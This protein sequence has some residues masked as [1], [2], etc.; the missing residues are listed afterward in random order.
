MAITLGSHH[1]GRGRQRAHERS[2]RG[3]R[4]AATPAPLEEEEQVTP[5]ASDAPHVASPLT[6]TTET[7]EPVIETSPPVIAQEVELNE[8]VETTT[9]PSARQKLMAEYG[10]YSRKPTEKELKEHN[11]FRARRIAAGYKSLVDIFDRRQDWEANP[12]LEAQKL[13]LAEKSGMPTYFMD[14]PLY[15]KEAETRAQMRDAYAQYEDLSPSTLNWMR[16]ADNLRIAR[17]DAVALDEVYKSYERMALAVTEGMEDW[18]V[19]KAFQS[20]TARF[21]E[22]LANT[23]RYIADTDEMGKT[24]FVPTMTEGFVGFAL[25][26]SG[27]DR[28]GML[29]RDLQK[30]YGPA[31]LRWIAGIQSSASRD[32]DPGEYMMPT[33]TAGRMVH[34]IVQSSP[35]AI[36]SMGRSLATNML[37]NLIVPGGGVAVSAGRSLGMRILGRIAN[38]GTIVATLQGAFGEGRMQAAGVYDEALTRGMPKE[39]AARI[40]E[41]VMRKNVALLL[42][43]EY[44]QNALTF[45]LGKGSTGLLSNAVRGSKWYARAAWVGEKML[46]AAFEGVE[47]VGQDLIDTYALGDEVDADALKWSFMVGVGSGGIYSVGGSTIQALGARAYRMMDTDAKI[48]RARK[49]R[50]G[51]EDV[52]AKISETKTASRIPEKMEEFVREATSGGMETVWIDGK[53]L[54]RFAQIADAESIAAMQEAMAAGDE[55]ASAEMQE[56]IEE[57]SRK[58]AEDLGIT[59]MA[60]YFEALATGTDVEVET[61][62]LLTKIGTDENYSIFKDHAKLSPTEMSAFEAE[63]AA[64][65]REAEARR[66]R[67]EVEAEAERIRTEGGALADLSKDIH[68][69]L[70][71]TGRK[72]I[73]GKSGAGA[74]RYADLITVSIKRKAEL[75]GIPLEEVA[76]PGA[77]QITDSDGIVRVRLQRANGR[78]VDITPGKYA[79]AK[80]TDRNDAASGESAG[81]MVE[82]ASNAF[83][84]FDFSE[85]GGERFKAEL[86][87]LRRAAKDFYNNVLA[88]TKVEHPGLGAIKFAKTGK[89]KSFSNSANY[90]KLLLFSKL[91]ELLESSIVIKEEENR[92]NRHPGRKRY[93]TLQSTA[94]IEGLP[95]LVTMT[96]YEDNQGNFYYNHGLFD[97]QDNVRKESSAQIRAL[98]PGDQGLRDTASTEDSSV[99]LR[100]ESE[101]LKG[102]K[103]GDSS[104]TEGYSRDMT[105]DGLNL[106]IHE[107]VFG[108]SAP[109]GWVIFGETEAMIELFEFANRATL[110]HEMGHVFLQDVLDAANMEESPENTKQ[111][112][113]DVS[114]WLGVADIDFSQPLSKENEN[115]WWTAQEKFAATFEAY[116]MEGKAPTEGLKKAFRAFKKWLIDIYRTVAGIRYLDAEGNWHQVE[117]SDQAR[118][119]FGRV[120]ASE[121][122]IEHEAV[123]NDMA[124]DNISMDALRAQVDENIPQEAFDMLDDAQYELI[125]SAKERLLSEMMGELTPEFQARI[126][127]RVEELKPFVR[128]IVEREPVYRAVSDMQAD[129]AL[130]IS[131]EEVLEGFG[132]T[133]LAALPE[134]IDA[135]NGVPLDTAAAAYGFSGAREMIDAMNG[136]LPLEVEVER[137]AT[138]QALRDA[139]AMEGSPERVASKAED[140]LYEGDEAL[141]KTLLEAGV[142]RAIAKSKTSRMKEAAWAE[143]VATKNQ[144][145]TDEDFQ[146]RFMDLRAKRRSAGQKAKSDPKEWK[147]WKMLH[148]EH[149][150]GL[151]EL[152]KQEAEG[153]IGAKESNKAVDPKPYIRTAKRAEREAQAAIKKD[154]MMAYAAARDRKAINDA[155]A[156]AAVRAGKEMDRRLHH[157]RKFANRPNKQ[158]FGVAPAYLAQIDAIL[159]RFDL[160]K[161]G[162]SEQQVQVKSLAK[163]V[164]ELQAKG[165]PVLIPDEILDANYRKAYGKMTVDELRALDDAV[166]NIEHLGKNEKKFISGQHK[167]KIDNAAEVIKS[168]LYKHYGL[169]G[170]SEMNPSATEARGVLKKMGK[171][172]GEF[173]ADLGM[174]EFIT[175]AMDGNKDLGPAHQ[176]I[177]QPIRD[178]VTK[179]TARLNEVFAEVNELTKKCYGTDKPGLG[180]IKVEL[181]ITMRDVNGNLIHGKNWV[182]TMEELIAAVCNMGNEGNL[183][184][185]MDGWLISRADCQ[186][187]VDALREQDVQ[188]VQGLLDIIGSLR[189]MVQEAAE[190]MTGVTPQWVEAAPIVTKFGT[191]PGGYYPIVTDLR[192]SRTAAYQQEISDLM[193]TVKMDHLSAH[194][195]DGHRKER[196]NNVSGRPPLLSLKV[197]DNHLAGVIHDAIFAPVVRDVNKIIHHPVVTDAVKQALGD[198]QNKVLNHWLRSV[199]SNNKNNGIMLDKTDRMFGIVQRG[200]TVMG[201]GM[202]TSGAI[203]QYTGF[204]PLASRI[205]GV[206]MVRAMMHEWQHPTETQR[207]VAE[208]SAFMREQMNGQDRDVRKMAEKWTVEGKGK[209]S[210]FRSV[211]LGAY[212][213]FQNRCNVPAWLECYKDGMKKF[214]NNEEKAIRYADSIIRQTQGAGSIADLTQFETSG[215]WKKMFT[216]FYSWFRVMHNLN[217]EMFRRV[218]NEPGGAHKLGVFM[219]HALWVW[220]LPSLAE[221]LIRRRGPDEDETWPQW[222]LKETALSIVLGPLKPIPFVREGVNAV[223]SWLEYG[224]R[225]DMYRFTPITAAFISPAKML[226]DAAVVTKDLWE[227]DE[228]DWTELGKSASETAGYWLGLP[229]RQAEKWW[230]VFA[231]T[232]NDEAG[233]LEGA[234]RVLMGWRK[235]RD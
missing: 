5:A 110:L 6:E 193:D 143:S 211:T 68:G 222:L 149:L 90:K 18:S 19:P 108:Q 224:F 189:P 220:I 45:G 105:R 106:N 186:K 69:Q 51:V 57:F 49:L 23:N 116:L 176:H 182:L 122:A 75:R 215:T 167:I 165:E 228:P 31:A 125:E 65:D 208:K 27:I 138:E 113:V 44:M 21:F 84:E 83:G 8:S 229:M 179:E 56:R 132:D 73:F 87:R 13:I 191:I 38:P 121:E 217:M 219:N 71:K 17:D 159:D 115:R 78:E 102:E 11:V 163:F 231:D 111:L 64:A 82:V 25:F 202:N 4:A 225:P 119:L 99:I 230:E 109:Y 148:R 123:M 26:A 136:A 55:N 30:Q 104:S 12:E 151:R 233:F 214:G 95:A 213:F 190:I 35:Y 173:L 14:D 58:L 101:K 66:L 232:I 88:G 137:R 62:K 168:N 48:Q 221:Q 162:Y 158:T 15:T 140:A 227:E 124:A 188:F 20:G 152:L 234:L 166:K 180:Q 85:P 81:T 198:E 150:K 79:S 67:E 126:T 156:S 196:A 52:T 205:G 37:M 201:L 86:T 218:K 170:P 47:E 2:G 157:L 226:F 80:V 1:S 60:A 155:C 92:D 142:A 216:M 10:I 195:R 204:L 107:A 9:P 141:D 175:R 207:F 177:F 91:R 36:Y 212:G 94:M 93:Y 59:D 164:E 181:D 77:V 183:Q 197:V 50:E 174:A 100:Q 96:V 134:D 146:Q 29:F 103:A 192:Y 53:E 32:I 39:E 128:S 235:P 153:V 154:D 74:I 210:A 145:Q 76:R 129:A 24:R 178:A 131:R 42:G 70:K 169:K 28:T 118:A 7:P 120:L 43:T 97:G 54:A 187:M 72:D 40:A 184:R 203:L 114:G 89:D 135:E 206:K 194:T 63:Q 185:M 147:E 144:D 61:A 127:K 41:G 171:W 33:S 16:T 98:E 209:L 130:R 200:A 46:S 112:W 133:T 117:L 172:T 34:D 3:L 160:R 223:E 22:K 139:G 199:A 161:K